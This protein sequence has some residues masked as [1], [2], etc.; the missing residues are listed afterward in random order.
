MDK[1]AIFNHF[2]AIFEEVL[3]TESKEEW[4]LYPEISM[5]EELLPGVQIYSGVTRCAVVDE[6]YDWIVKFDISDAPY[7]ER[8]VELYER[9]KSYG[10]EDC[11][12]PVLYAGRYEDAENGMW[13]DL[14]AYKKAK[15][16]YRSHIYD[17]S[18]VKCF[19]G[20]P[21]SD[22]NECIAADL[23]ED[24]GID[25]FRNLNL[26][27]EENEINDIHCGNVGWIAGKL[28]LI[29]YAGYH[30]SSEEDS[31]YSSEED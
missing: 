6:A 31:Y 29:D 28:V 2:A 5:S 12:T 4:L 30:S 7:C 13:W 16:G 21:L 19:K 15:C 18:S 22:R 8:E 11:L 20:S 10:C 24:W 9:A 3:R 25:M 1:E 27:C 14:Y 23:I 26:F 17:D